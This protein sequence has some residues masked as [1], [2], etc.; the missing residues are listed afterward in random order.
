MLGLAAK[1]WVFV[2]SVA[3]VK[4]NVDPLTK[5]LVNSLKLVPRNLDVQEAKRLSTEAKTQR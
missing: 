3:P 1:D 2:L 5:E 4:K